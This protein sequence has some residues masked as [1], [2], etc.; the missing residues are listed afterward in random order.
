MND[1]AESLPC[2]AANPDINRR[3][4]GP[5][6]LSPYN[7]PCIKSSITTLISP[8]AQFSREIHVSSITYF[9]R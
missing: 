2:A 6:P 1:D 8:P 9:L 7:I 4:P 5:Y 3:S